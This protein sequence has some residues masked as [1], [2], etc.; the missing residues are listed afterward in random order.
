MILKIQPSIQ[1]FYLGLQNFSLSLEITQPVFKKKGFLS[2]LFDT[3]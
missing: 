3:T 2:Y 1:R